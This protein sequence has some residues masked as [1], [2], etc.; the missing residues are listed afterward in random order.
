MVKEGVEEGRKIWK[1]TDDIVA[2]ILVIAWVVSKFS[3]NAIPDW[4][5][6]AVLGYIFGKSIP[7]PK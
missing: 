1:Y 5:M 2:I 7:L 3:G 6:T 4:V